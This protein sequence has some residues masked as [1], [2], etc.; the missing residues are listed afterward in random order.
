MAVAL[1]KHTSLQGI[2]H[3]VVE[4]LREAIDVS[5]TKK[6]LLNIRNNH[7]LDEFFSSHYPQP[8]ESADFDDWNDKV[9]QIDERGL[10]ERLML[11]ELEDFSTRVHGMTARPHMV[12]EVEDL[13]KWLHQLATKPEGVD[14]PLQMRRAYISVGI[15]LIAKMSTISEQGI[16]PYRTA[17]EYNLRKKLD[18]IYLII[19]DRPSVGGRVLDERYRSLCQ[20]IVEETNWTKNLKLHFKQEYNYITPHGEKR[21]GWIARY[22]RVD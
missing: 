15:V 5:L 16:G 3:L 13:V 17:I 4:P 10:F 18:T 6:L 11:V 21:T 20:D 9:T 2:R 19:W 1:V 14:V 12:G 22:Y 8:G 7:A